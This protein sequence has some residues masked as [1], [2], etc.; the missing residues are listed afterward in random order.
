MQPGLIRRHRLAVAAPR[1]AADSALLKLS[2]CCEDVVARDASFGSCFLMKLPLP[3]TY[4]QAHVG[5]VLART[6][7][8]SDGGTRDDPTLER[9]EG[10]ACVLTHMYSASMAR[11]CVGAKVVPSEQARADGTPL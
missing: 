7:L 6:P 4:P 8:L 9:S 3:S 11:A 5:R 2:C 1:A 10:H